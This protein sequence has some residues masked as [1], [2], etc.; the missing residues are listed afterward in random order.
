MLFPVLFRNLLIDHIDEAIKA[1]AVEIFATDWAWDCKQ[2]IDRLLA[3]VVEQSKLCSIM[4]RN[5]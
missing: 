1:L 2:T 5:D 3:I 4:H